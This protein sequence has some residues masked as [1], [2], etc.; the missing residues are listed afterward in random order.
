[1]RR[2]PVD[3]LA[4]YRAI[5]RRPADPTMTK[6]IGARLTAPRLRPDTPREARRRVTAYE[7]HRELDRYGDL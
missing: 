1:M 5:L 7:M 6:R 3:R 4:V 2:R